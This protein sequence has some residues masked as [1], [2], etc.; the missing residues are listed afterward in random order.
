M[1]LISPLFRILIDY[2]ILILFLHQNLKKSFNEL[3]RNNTGTEVKREVEAIVEEIK[4]HLSVNIDLL[5]EILDV[6]A[7]DEYLYIHSLNVAVISNLIGKWI[8]L[9]QEDLD[10]L[11]LSGL[12][13]DIG[14]LKVK[15][16]ILHKPGKLTEAEFSEMK[17]HPAYSHKMLMDMG[18]TD[19]KL[20]KAV[21]LHH[22][23]IDGTGYP[24]GIGEE[25]IPLHAKIIA[26]A[27]IFDAMT[28]NRVYKER[29]SPF[30]VLEM[31]QNQTF[32]KLDY[33]IIMTF[34]RKFTEYY[35]GADVIL[36]NGAKAKIVSL[37]TY[38]LTK[39]LLVTSQG[40]F[41]DISR[42]RNVQIIDFYQK[43]SS[44]EETEYN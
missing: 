34:I 36:S 27:D 40:F 35:V 16:D 29:V 33:S 12:L 39:P 28:S 6:K 43:D 8:G 10:I 11:I 42:N 37:N 15:Q 17:K 19:T 20:L 13:H 21:T 30:K 7:V 41:I 18:Y 4:D 3:S 24:L 38:E 2:I 14:K 25:K 44:C 9:N 31:F 5:N 32:G 26:I 23:K 22:E 1:S